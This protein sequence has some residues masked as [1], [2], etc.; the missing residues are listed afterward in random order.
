MAAS[1]LAEQTMSG[2]EIIG[3]PLD[4]RRCRWLRLQAEGQSVAGTT[5]ERFDHDPI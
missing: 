3:A 2:D 4:G 5:D 1:L